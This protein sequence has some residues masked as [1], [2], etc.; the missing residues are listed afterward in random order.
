[1]SDDGSTLWVA[2]DGA[3]AF[4]KVTLGA[5]PVVGPLIHLP[6]AF[7]QSFFDVGAIATL[8]GAPL[9]TVVSMTN[10][11]GY[12]GEVRVFDDGAQRTTSATPTTMVS[13]LTAGPS[14]YVFGTGANYFP[15][16]FFVFRI[17]ASGI[18]DTT[19]TFNSVVRDYTNNLVYTGNRVFSDSGDVVDVTNP[20][21]PFRVNGLPYRGPVALRDAQSVLMLTTTNSTT[22]PFT[23]R[24]DI[25]IYS[26]STLS[27]TGLAPV[28]SSVGITN[29]YLTKLVYAGADAAAFTM[30]D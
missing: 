25:R 22:F 16:A 8:P 6:R 14:G 5:T 13:A 20:M 11:Y 10:G 28:P 30:Y 26:P 29:S 23:T 12:L 19:T 17:G 4:R 24:N 21:A 15:G 2:I 3:H 27:Q 7:S 18:I 1:L 9:S